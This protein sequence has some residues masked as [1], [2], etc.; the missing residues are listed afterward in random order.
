LQTAGE[1]Q[2]EAVRDLILNLTDQSIGSES[3]SAVFGATSGSSSLSQECSLSVKH[4][5]R[6]KAFKNV[7]ILKDC[8]AVPRFVTAYRD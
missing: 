3:L 2:A 5:F 7:Q 4:L 6:K 1:E 8:F